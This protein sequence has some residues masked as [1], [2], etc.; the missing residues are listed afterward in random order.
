MLLDPGVLDKSMTS[1]LGYMLSALQVQLAVIHDIHMV[2]AQSKSN[3]K[4]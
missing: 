1:V 2:I 3:I 4:L